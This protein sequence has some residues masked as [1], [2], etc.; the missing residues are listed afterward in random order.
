M[1]AALLTA[2]EALRLSLPPD[3]GAVVRHGDRERALHALRSLEV[4]LGPGEA[5]TPLMP[6]QLEVLFRQLTHV[7]S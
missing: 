7:L 3:E 1:N 5:A 6:M 2:V 4:L